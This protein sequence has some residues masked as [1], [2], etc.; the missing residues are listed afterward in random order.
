MSNNTGNDLGIFL[1]DTTHA[2]NLNCLVTQDGVRDNVMN[3][4]LLKFLVVK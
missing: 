3:Y 1:L 2:H 4:A